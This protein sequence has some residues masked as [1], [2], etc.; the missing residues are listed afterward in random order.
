[1]DISIAETTLT[2][3]LANRQVKD[4]SAL[5]Y[6]AISPMILSSDVVCSGSPW[7]AWSRLDSTNNIVRNALELNEFQVTPLYIRPYITLITFPQVHAV[8][9]SPCAFVPLIGRVRFCPCDT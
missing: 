6:L 5:A 8:L 2:H 3:K 4:I 9:G 7:T 1:M